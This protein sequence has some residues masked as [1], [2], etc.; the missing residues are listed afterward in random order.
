MANSIRSSAYSSLRLGVLFLSQMPVFH[1][2][3]N[4]R[5]SARAARK[6]GPQSDQLARTLVLQKEVDEF[7][8]LNGLTSN[9]L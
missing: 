8:D 7:R 3:R 1:R 6:T 4:Y 5:T 2:A 9:C